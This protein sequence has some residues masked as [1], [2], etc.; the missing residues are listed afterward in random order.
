MSFIAGGEPTDWLAV[1]VNT[2]IFIIVRTTKLL[3][4]MA[5][6]DDFPANDLLRLP[7]GSDE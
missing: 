5:M 1:T 2:R 4:T 6:P 7:V 3:C